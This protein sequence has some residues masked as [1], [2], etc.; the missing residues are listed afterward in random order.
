V[1]PAHL[2]PIALFGR[3]GSGKTTVSDY[4]VKQYGYFHCSPGGICRQISRLLFQ[5]ESKTILNQVNDAI[6]TLG[7]LVL[8]RAALASVPEQTE[9]I[10]FDSMRFMEDYEFF[11][12]Q[13]YSLWRVEC[14]EEV[15]IG[16]LAGRGQDFKVGQD[17]LHRGEL[18]LSDC[19]FD[20]T[21]YNSD[22]SP[23]QL[24]RQIDVALRLIE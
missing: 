21:L 9:R 2:P 5:A 17:D 24:Y 7:K 10:V 11:T 22:P 19:Q 12:T 1:K 6:Q 18:E 16:R 23:E 4:L 14:A 13:Q 8:T 3:S 20:L 15:R